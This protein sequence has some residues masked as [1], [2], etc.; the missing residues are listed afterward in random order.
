MK[1]LFKIIGIIAIVAIIGFSM[2]ACVNED[3]T[4]GTTATPTANLGSGQYEKGTP[5][6]LSTETE[7]AAIYYNTKGTEHPAR[8]DCDEYTGPIILNT[9]LNITAY[10]YKSGMS[11]SEYL[12]V[13]Y[14][15]KGDEFDNLT[16]LDEWLKANPV[17]TA[18]TSYTIKL[19]VGDSLVGTGTVLGNNKTKYVNLDLSGS[20]STSIPYAEF[21]GCTNLTGVTIPNS[22]TSIEDSAFNG[23]TGITE[24]TIPNGVTIIK[25]YAFSYCTGI[26]AITIPDSVTQILG[27]AFYGTSLTGEIN[28]SDKITSI[29]SG[30]FGGCKKL[31]ALKVAET[32]S[33]YLSEGGILYNK[34]KTT[35]VAYPAGLAP[36]DNLLI[37]I[38]VTE[39]GNGAFSGCNNFD[40]IA[41]NS[42]TSIGRSAFEDCTSLT[43]VIIPDSVTSIGTDAF[44]S[45]RSLTSVTIPSNIDKIENAVF[46]LCNSLTSVTFK[47]AGINFGTGSFVNP[48][49]T[50]NLKTAYTAGGA[51]TYTRPDS[52]S[53]TWTKQ[54]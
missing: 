17:N 37:P 10:A 43:L 22:V 14:I 8:D 44:S 2:A 36:T 12:R 45:A 41:F 40:R 30:A 26:T 35:L 21:S 42:V 46:Y 47:V 24:I 34:A 53:T 48:T 16:K 11:P 19:N 25:S 13:S 5:I 23:C 3:S 29:G 1:N 15:L 28:I 52:S 33:T 9:A 18:A 50:N 27:K 32:H 4:S 49:N 6:I 20:T 7:G 31:T 38:T 51:G 54:P 39:I